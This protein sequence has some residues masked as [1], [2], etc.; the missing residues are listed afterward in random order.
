MVELTNAKASHVNT[1]YKIQ[2]P[3][4]ILFSWGQGPVLSA[5]NIG[6]VSLYS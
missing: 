5:S 4:A 6:P 2:L 1:I 3:K